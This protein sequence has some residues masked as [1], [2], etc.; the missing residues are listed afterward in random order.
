MLGGDTVSEEYVQLARCPETYD[1]GVAKVQCAFSDGHDG[2]HY[3]DGDNP[4][5]IFYAWGHDRED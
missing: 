5:A 1:L 2:H 4:F 3:A